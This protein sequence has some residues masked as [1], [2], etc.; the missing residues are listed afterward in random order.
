MLER[1]AEQIH[2]RSR[3]T[4]ET[5]QQEHGKSANGPSRPVRIAR[6][7][8]GIAGVRGRVFGLL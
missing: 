3:Q 8:R 5:V 4:D 2:R 6:E 1:S 7:G